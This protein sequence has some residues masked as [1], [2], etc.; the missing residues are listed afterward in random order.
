VCNSVSEYFVERDI[1]M[2]IYKVQNYILNSGWLKYTEVVRDGE[3]NSTLLQY[4]EL[5]K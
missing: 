3:G 2:V 5:H 1:T 4:L